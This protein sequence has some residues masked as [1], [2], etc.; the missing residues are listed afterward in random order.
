LS[1][2]LP[3]GAAVHSERD[4]D[5]NERGRHLTPSK[6]RHALTVRP[7]ASASPARPAQMQHLPSPLPQTGRSRHPLHVPSD[8]VKAVALQHHDALDGKT[9]LRGS[10]RHSGQALDDFVN[11][12]ED[13]VLST[14]ASVLDFTLSGVSPK[15]PRLGRTSRFHLPGSILPYVPYLGACLAHLRSL[16]L[17]NL[18]LHVT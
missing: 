7:G 14:V 6:T 2:T 15:M 13:G 11:S 16:L 10:G 18:R 8:V 5:G 9:P 17:P 1:Q 4:K 3:E 12:F